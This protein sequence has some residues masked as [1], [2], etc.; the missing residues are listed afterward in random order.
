MK[1]ETVVCSSKILEPLLDRVSELNNTTAELKNLVF[2]LKGEVSLLK[3]ES[4]ENGQ[5]KPSRF[6]R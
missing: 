6:A 3:E 1:N 2:E 5:V 4:R